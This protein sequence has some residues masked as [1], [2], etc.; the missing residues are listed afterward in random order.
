MVSRHYRP[1]PGLPG[2]TAYTVLALREGL[3][4]PHLPC[5]PQA[6]SEL[7][8]HTGLLKQLLFKLQG[9]KRVPTGGGRV[10]DPALILTWIHAPGDTC[11]LHPQHRPLHGL[12][13]LQWGTPISS[14]RGP[15]PSGQE[16]AS[17]AQEALCPLTRSPSHHQGFSWC[18]GIT[19]EA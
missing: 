5:R 15:L 14:P 10:I 18:Q 1:W 12:Y 11:S 6:A 16:A 7:E 13:W 8:R 2:Y 19:A 3:N 17:L 4:K 9:S